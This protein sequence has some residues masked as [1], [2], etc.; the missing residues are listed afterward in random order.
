MSNINSIK[1][2]LITHL[3]NN[4][5]GCMSAISIY[6]FPNAYTVQELICQLVTKINEVV[7]NTNT[8][9][10]IVNDT[11]NWLLNEGLEDELVKQLE[12]WIDDGTLS[13]IIN[14]NIFQTILSSISELDDKFVKL[15]DVTWEGININKNKILELKNELDLKS[16]EIETHKKKINDLEFKDKELQEEINMLQQEFSKTRVELMDRPLSKTFTLQNLNNEF[17][18]NSTFSN[19]ELSTM[20]VETYY[21]QVTYK[22]PIPEDRKIGAVVGQCFS[23]GNNKWDVKVKDVTREGFKFCLV[24]TSTGER[25]TNSDAVSSDYATIIAFNHTSATRTHD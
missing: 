17:V 19:E 11:V 23:I 7:D 10:E 21:I 20:R 25:V 2:R 8:Y 4:Y 1:K 24:D 22:N 5:I 16:E 15:N 3:N 6:D 12:K 14:Q 9:T 18:P 13:N